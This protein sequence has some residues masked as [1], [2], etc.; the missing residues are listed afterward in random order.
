ME[1]EGGECEV[2][3]LR[4]GRGGVDHEEGEVEGVGC[5]GKTGTGEGARRKGPEGEGIDRVREGTTW[6]E[7]GRKGSRLARKRW[8]E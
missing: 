5:W 6:R 4:E 8:A 1:A 3:D 2:G 7:R